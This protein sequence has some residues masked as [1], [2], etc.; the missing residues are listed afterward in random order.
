MYVIIFSLLFN[1][2]VPFGWSRLHFLSEQR[3]FQTYKR[4]GDGIMLNNHEMDRVCV[5]LTI[6]S[7][8]RKKSLTKKLLKRKIKSKKIRN[9]S[10]FKKSVTEKNW[11]TQTIIE[12]NH[13]KK[14]SRTSCKVVFIL[15]IIL[16]FVYTYLCMIVFSI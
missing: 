1:Y 9:N 5:L 11:T 14:Q 2:G 6:D 10:S 4:L 8:V 7:R 15:L 16:L 3:E 13:T 12:E